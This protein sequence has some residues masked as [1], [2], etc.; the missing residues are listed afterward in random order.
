MDA[1]L[2][3]HWQFKNSLVDSVGAV[4]ISCQNPVSYA[5]NHLGQAEEALGPLSSNKCSVPTTP[6]FNFPGPFTVSVWINC[7]S[8]KNSYEA[9]F[10]FG[11]GVSTDN[12]WFGF[13]G[14]GARLSYWSYNSVIEKIFSTTYLTPKTWNFLALTF[15]GTVYTLY[16]NGVSDISKAMF[17]PK[18]VQRSKNYIG[19]AN[20]GERQSGEDLTN[21][22]LDDFRIYSRALSPVEIRS[23]NQSKQNERPLLTLDLKVINQNFPLFLVYAISRFSKTQGQK[24]V[25]ELHFPALFS[26]S[27][28]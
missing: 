4:S 9:I 15:D 17:P 18:N 25:I 19:S 3:A 27:L 1:G 7:I 12:L 24:I 16:I 28:K 23:L 2:V 10:D 8:I 13:Y 6:Y 26:D 20:R 22:L 11:N 14:T 5:Q 21:T